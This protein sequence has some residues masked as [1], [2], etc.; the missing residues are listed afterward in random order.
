MYLKLKCFQL[1]SHAL[2]FRV[3]RESKNTGDKVS[4]IA[5]SLFSLTNEEF[6]R[7]TQKLA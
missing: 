5:R 7:T 3:Y 4:P 6:F 1:E 2:H